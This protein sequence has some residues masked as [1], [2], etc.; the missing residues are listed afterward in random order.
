MIRFGRRDLL[1]G[2]ASQ[3]LSSSFRQKAV[4]WVT[5]DSTSPL[6]SDI[7]CLG[8]ARTSDVPLLDQMVTVGY[9]EAEP[10]Y[11]TMVG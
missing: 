1:I 4:A 5:L 3:D 10:I 6:N 2:W 8:S 7:M 11:F 9:E